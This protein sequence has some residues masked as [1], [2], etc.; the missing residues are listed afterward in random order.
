MIQNG[1]RVFFDVAAKAR[2]YRVESG[3]EELGL[4]REEA[5]ALR[6]GLTIALDAGTAFD[7]PDATGG[8]T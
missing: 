5:I 1:V 8:H 3:G 4:T 6:D 2:P 7:M